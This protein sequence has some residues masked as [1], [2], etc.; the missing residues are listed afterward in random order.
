V[1]ELQPLRTRVTVNA[2]CVKPI[3]RRASDAKSDKDGP[4]N[5]NN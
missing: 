2:T 4:E 1:L 3:L 5:V